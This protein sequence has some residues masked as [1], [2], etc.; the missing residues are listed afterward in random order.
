MSASSAHRQLEQ[1]R[2]LP[3]TYDLVIGDF[4]REAATRYVNILAQEERRFL[5]RFLAKT[6]TP[7]FDEYRRIM[8]TLVADIAF[9]KH[10][11]IHRTWSE[12]GRLTDDVLVAVKAHEVPEDLRREL[13]A[14]IQDGVASAKRRGYGTVR[15]VMPCN[16][17]SDVL[18]GAV[19]RVTHEQV[20]FADVV[21][22]GVIQSAIEQLR[23][24]GCIGDSPILVLGSSLAQ[25]QYREAGATFGLDVLA[26]SA[27]QQA[28]IDEAVTICIGGDERALARIRGSL[29][30][31][32]IAPAREVYGDIPVLEACTDFDFGL[33][34]DSVRLLAE[35]YVGLTQSR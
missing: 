20:D 8:F 28:L 27:E 23:S 24:T 31:Q 11:M 13:A 14:V 4:G 32:I 3:I 10:G 1:L 25:D 35:A 6:G 29:E 18:T 19:D 33:G 12:H 17:L 26:V 22:H 16:S 5:E 2:D 34:H 9:L 7:F 21:A 30:S 15:V